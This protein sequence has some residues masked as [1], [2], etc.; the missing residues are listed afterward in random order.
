MWTFSKRECVWLAHVQVQ[1]S[2]Q[3]HVQ[4]QSSLAHVQVQSLLQAHVQVQ[5]S[6]HKTNLSPEFIAPSA[7]A[8]PPDADHGIATVVMDQILIF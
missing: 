2:L 1:C 7:A 4:V 5:N 6:L 8:L 3:T